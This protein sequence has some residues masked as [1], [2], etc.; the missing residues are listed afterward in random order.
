M[1]D[2]EIKAVVFDLGETLLNFGRLSTS[3]LFS[4]AARGSYEF[5]TQAGQPVGR[6][7]CYLW[8]NVLGL[9]TRALLANITGRDFDSLSTLKAYGAKK[10]FSLSAEQWEELNWLWYKPL[11]RRASVEAGLAG[12]LGRFKSAGLKLGI[13]SNTFV[14][15]CS[16]ERHLDEAGLGG[17]FDVRIYSYQFKFRKPD[18]R[19]FLEA[20][21]RLG[22]RPDNIVFVGDRIDKDIKGALKAGM[23]AVLKKAYTNIGKRP[24]NGVTVTNSICEL[25]RSILRMRTGDGRGGEEKNPI[26]NIFDAG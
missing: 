20:A 13:I 8:R 2:N 23:Q 14:N 9:R 18:R 7:G 22:I 10:G 4:E 19:I 11:A 12:M 5:L 25:S 1:A 26:N 6:F 3:R 21:R 16:L 15:A 24:P 17:F